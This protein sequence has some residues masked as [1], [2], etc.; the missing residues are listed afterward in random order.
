MPRPKKPFA[1][2]RLTVELK[3][4]VRKRLEELR[5][6]VLADTLSEVLRRSIQLYDLF[7]TASKK[8]AKIFVRDKD[9]ER[10]IVILEA[11]LMTAPKQS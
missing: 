10:E 3:K 1:T 5:E 7:F 4:E 9:G 2:S 11:G 6:E 8:G